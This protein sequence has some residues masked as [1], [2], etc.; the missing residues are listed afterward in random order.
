[1]DIR[2][3]QALVAIADTGS[4]SLAAEALKTVQS[5]I[6]TRITKLEDELGIT[7]VDRRDGSV[8]ADGRHVLE[9]GRRILS[10][11]DAVYSDVRAATE[12]ISGTVTIGMI[13]TTGRWL[14]PHLMR[15]LLAALPAVQLRIIEGSNFL[16]EPQV[17]QGSIDIAVVSEPI[18]HPDL[19]STPLF[20][21][22]LVLIT[23][24]TS[25]LARHPRLTVKDLAQ[26]ELLLPLS[27]TALRAD[28]D[29]ACRDAG[30]SLTPRIEL[31][32]VRTLAALA[33]DGYG[34]A[35]LP[36]TTLSRHLIGSFVAVPIDGLPPRRVS[37]AT[38][39]YGFPSAPVRALRDL[40]MNS[41]SDPLL[42][43]TGVRR[44]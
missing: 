10:E 38:R 14:V 19:Q 17:A 37:V 3:I 4:F 28:I 21:E 41:V 2:Q 34:P 40:V 15:N 22:D 9:R 5:N 6:S 8:T 24:S 30:V 16:L 26:H 18:T 12:S 27:G 39:K 36:A 29:T 31:D 33:F 13:G 43:P 35:I 20:T 7:L 25:P 11:M 1:V 42:L 23:P 44:A 32:G